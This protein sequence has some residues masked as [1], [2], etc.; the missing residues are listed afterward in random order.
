MFEGAASVS[1]HFGGVGPVVTADV[2]DPHPAAIM[3]TMAQSTA[4]TGAVRETGLAASAVWG[5]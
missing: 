3:A 4:D 5:E 2:E 1:W